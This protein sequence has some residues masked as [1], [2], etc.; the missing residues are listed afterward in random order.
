MDPLDKT[1]LT[2]RGEEERVCSP[3]PPTENIS[4]PT[5]RT[6]QVI[7]HP[8]YRAAL[9][10]LDDFLRNPLADNGQARCALL[11]GPPRCGK[12]TLAK[13]VMAIVEASPPQA[14]RGDPDM[15]RRRV[16]YVDTPAA[17][18]QRSMAETILLAAGDIVTGRG[19]QASLTGRVAHLLGDL[20][21]ELLVLDEFHHLITTGKKT[22]AAEVAEWVKSL[23]NTGV[24][25]ILLA[26]IDPV[27]NIVNGHGQLEGRC[28]CQPTV[29]VFGWNTT[30]EQKTFRLLLRHLQD[31]L[32]VPTTFSLS[33]W[34]F[35]QRMH[36][37]SAGAIG[38]VTLLLEK[39]V[40]L[41]RQR[42]LSALTLDLL[43]EA[44][45]DWS[46]AAARNPFR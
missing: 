18:T 2:K 30:D 23:L 27:S 31:Q 17:A 10:K 21:T 37:A 28:W 43:A 8:A 38:N 42:N 33:D 20:D 39:T 34:D 26:G 12:T 19:S 6:A 3:A 45:A 44:F 35:A 16:I 24:C 7:L 40:S 14:R 15:D 11:S 46:L 36:Q 32:A 22:Q 29:Q 9:A 4:Q 1:I 13:R 5:N 25:P 41:A